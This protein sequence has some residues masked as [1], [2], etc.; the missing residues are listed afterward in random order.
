MRH[1]QAAHSGSGAL[2]NRQRRAEES[3]L[4]CFRAQNPSHASLGC[5]PSQ[6]LSTARSL[7]SPWVL[8][9]AA[10]GRFLCSGSSV[11]LSSCSGLRCS[12][13]SQSSNHVRVVLAVGSFLFHQRLEALVLQRLIFGGSRRGYRSNTNLSTELIGS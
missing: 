11:S 13:C 6:R 1:P 12:C 5:F 9:I 7:A 4:V 10:D 2:C 3:L 8:S